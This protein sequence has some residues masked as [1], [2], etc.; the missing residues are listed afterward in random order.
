[1]NR[2][3]WSYE[4]YTSTSLGDLREMVRDHQPMHSV[5]G[6]LPGQWVAALALAP[7]DQSSRSELLAAIDAALGGQSPMHGETVSFG[8]VTSSHEVPVIWMFPGQGAQRVGLLRSLFERNELFRT[9]LETLLREASEHI[10]TDVLET[11]YP[12]DGANEATELRLMQTSFCQPVMVGLTL[13]LAETFSRAGLRIDGAMGHSLGEFAATAAIG[14]VDPQDLMRFVARRG[15]VMVESR[16][17]MDPGAMA[18]VMASAEAIA[19]ALGD[20]TSVSVANINQPRQT[21][22][23]GAT[24]DIERAVKSLRRSR[25]PGKRLPVS[26][27]FHSPLME[28]ASG[29]LVTAVD[30]LTFSD[31]DVPLFS[32]IEGNSIMKAHAYRDMFKR[33]ATSPVNFIAALRE[34]ER[35]GKRPLLLEMGAGKTLSS[36]ARHTLG[37]DSDALMLASVEPDAEECLAKAMVSLVKLG[38]PVATGIL[39]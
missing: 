4:T 25:L 17:G 15:K 8:Q 27:A 12:A 10:G 34:A 7:D 36:F 13:A 39:G 11:L 38:V 37:E 5:D 31:T 18:A 2:R 21:V 16:E 20:D 35:F 1:M 9:T 22:I 24:A 26:H 6:V 23:S 28:D 33:H 14:G 3:L 30:T 19:E 32:A 29:T